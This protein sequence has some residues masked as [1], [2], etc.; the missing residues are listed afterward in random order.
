LVQAVATHNVFTFLAFE[1]VTWANASAHLAD[2]GHGLVAELVLRYQQPL[3][4][5]LTHLFLDDVFIQFESKFFWILFVIVIFGELL[6][7]G[8]VCL[9]CSRN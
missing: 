2:L 1:Q 7:T 3:A 5:S 9:L 8:K 4:L 6:E